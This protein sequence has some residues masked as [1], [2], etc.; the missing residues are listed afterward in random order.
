MPIRNLS[1]TVAAYDEGRVHI[2][3]FYKAA[4]VTTGDGRWHDWAF[5]S[6]QPAYDARIG[7]AGQFNP[8]VA[9]RNDAI[10]FPDIPS[11][12]ERRL[13]RIVLRT[14]AS[15][16]S[17]ATTDALLYDLVGVYPL[18]DGD[19]TDLQEFTNDDPLPRYSDGIGVIPVL[20]NHVAPMVASCAG[21][22]TYTDSEDVQHT[23][24]MGVS[25]GGA[26]NVVSGW[27]ATTSF[28]SLSLPTNGGRGVKAI[29]SIQFTTAPGGLFAIYMIRPITT[30][31]NN[32]GG[33][34]AEKIATE[35]FLAINHAWHYPRIR[36]GAHLGFFL[37]PNG[38]S[39][40]FASVY[41]Y[42]EFIWG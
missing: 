3:R 42:L 35:K 31:Q 38:G 12:Q 21:T 18:I 26:G 40:T 19:N 36:D 37:R 22:Y 30:L 20:V 11:D 28:G 32:D 16:T 24:P 15:G 6:G 41:G 23:S 25:R 4:N 33:L 10:W 13:K 17:Q 27:N 29:N 5:A 39:R 2:Q 1:D 34:T 9:T 14:Q 7:V 8:V